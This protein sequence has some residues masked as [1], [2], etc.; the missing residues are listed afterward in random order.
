MLLRDQIRDRWLARKPAAKFRAEHEIRCGPSGSSVA[1]VERVD[2]YKPKM[3]DSR[4]EH[5]IDILAAVKPVD[6]GLHFFGKHSRPGRFVM[7]AL[8]SDGT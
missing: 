2:G 7:N 1:I 6:E 3:S 4:F 5:G 8:A